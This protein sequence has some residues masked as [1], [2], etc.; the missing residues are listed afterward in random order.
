MVA[1]SRP[2]NRST[3]L[4]L[5]E[6][7][8]HATS[9]SSHPTRA[10]AEVADD[11]NPPLRAAA[12]SGLLFLRQATSTAS[13]RC[14]GYQWHSC[15]GNAGGLAAVGATLR[16]GFEV[17]ADEVELYDQIEAVD[18]VVTGEGRLDVPSFEGKVIGGVAELAREADVPVLAVVGVRDP[19]FDPPV[20][21][22]DLT[23]LVG[24][25]RATGDTSAA[26]TEVVAARLGAAG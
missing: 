21:V 9:S 4:L 11:D 5:L 20:E 1:L 15:F 25:A 26:I 17:V 22:L 10:T 14:R 23:A 18:L 16:E 19:G 8:E 12:A 3:G 7:A 24:A 6:V 13:E 2:T